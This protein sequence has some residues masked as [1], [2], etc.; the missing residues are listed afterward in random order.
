[1]MLLEDN[2]ESSSGET[3]S[4]AEKELQELAKQDDAKLKRLLQPRRA[5]AKAK[6]KAKA[7]PPAAPL[8]PELQDVPEPPPSVANGYVT[9][10]GIRVGRIACFFINPVNPSAHIYCSRH[11][12]CKVWVTLKHVPESKRLRQWIIIADRFP[13]EDAHRDAFNLL[14]Y[15]HRE[16]PLGNGKPGG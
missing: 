10:D 16:G 6:A 2:D 5:K 9:L 3:S 15:G 11:D 12:N 1:M 14:V 13:N 8:P 4:E 7:T